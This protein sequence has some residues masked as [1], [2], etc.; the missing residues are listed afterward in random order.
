[1]LQQLVTSG[2]ILI[3]WCLILLAVIRYLE[4]TLLQ[5]LVNDCQQQQGRQQRDSVRLLQDVEVDRLSF[6]S[7][8]A[9]TIK[10]EILAHWQASCSCFKR[11]QN[12]VRITEHYKM[13][14]Q[15]LRKLSIF[16]NPL[17][18]HF[19]LVRPGATFFYEH[20]RLNKDVQHSLLCLFGDFVEVD[21]TRLLCTD[22]AI[23]TGPTFRLH[24]TNKKKDAVFLV[25]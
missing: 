18:P 5:T 8:S 4:P 19:V 20:A 9:S 14:V 6:L 12:V 1:M 17:S 15:V 13:T 7:T 21:G 11:V 24:N 3:L 16:H 22:D 23:N 25:L 2:I 10:D